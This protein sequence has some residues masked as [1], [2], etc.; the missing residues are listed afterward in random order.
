MGREIR[1]I[2]I[3]THTH[4]YTHINGDSLWLAMKRVCYWLID[5]A[6]NFNV[7]QILLIINQTHQ[8]GL[9]PCK[10][11]CMIGTCDLYK[12]SH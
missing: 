3:Y 8:V 7:W 10:K 9:V 6:V 5:D 12:A 1:Y 4:T 11:I 2:Y